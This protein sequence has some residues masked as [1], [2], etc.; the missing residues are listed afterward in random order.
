MEF[1]LGKVIYECRLYKEVSKIEDKPQ[2]HVL[3]VLF[4]GMCGKHEL[5]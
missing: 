2:V 4:Q 5:V 3:K 1:S